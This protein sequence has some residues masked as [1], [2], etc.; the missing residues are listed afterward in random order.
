MGTI[1]VQTINNGDSLDANPIDLNFDEIV[2]EF[3]GNIDNT[4]IKPNAAIDGSKISP[5]TVSIAATSTKANLGR[6]NNSGDIWCL[7]VANVSITADGSN[8]FCNFTF[9]TVLTTTTG[10]YCLATI[11][12]VVGGSDYGYYVSHTT[13]GGTT[14]AQARVTGANTGIVTFFVWGACAS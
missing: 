4:N 10:A 13:I 14:F 9:P 3:N 11:G 12:A 1:T 8:G 6:V 5:A 2:N 7:Q